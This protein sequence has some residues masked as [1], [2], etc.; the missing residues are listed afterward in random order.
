MSRS[1]EQVLYVL[2]MVVVIVGVDV[3]FLRDR[4]WLR[5]VVNIAI[6]AIFLV[7]YATLL[8]GR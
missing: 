6:V 2:L 4:A 8:S 5:L 7:V 3:A 1:V